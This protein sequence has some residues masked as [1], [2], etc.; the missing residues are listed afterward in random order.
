MKEVPENL[1]PQFDRFDRGKDGVL[2]KDDFGR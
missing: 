1:H 2:T